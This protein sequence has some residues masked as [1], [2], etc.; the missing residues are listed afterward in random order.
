MLETVCRECE[1]SQ[2]VIPRMRAIEGLAI[3]THTY[4][5]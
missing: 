2:S 3:I 4:I 5:T 1:S